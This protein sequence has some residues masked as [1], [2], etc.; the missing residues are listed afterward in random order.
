[1]PIAGGTT[2]GTVLG[3]RATTWAKEGLDC[4]G[5]R[6]ENIHSANRSP[7]QPPR[8]TPTHFPH[9]HSSQDT[10]AIR[11]SHHECPSPVPSTN[12]RTAPYGAS[13]D[14]GE[15]FGLAPP[16]LLRRLDDDV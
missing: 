10:T 5:R 2:A 16:S 6:T 8:H 11:Y 13:V 3:S 9:A 7:S 1:M 14:G 4:K 12:T 15:T